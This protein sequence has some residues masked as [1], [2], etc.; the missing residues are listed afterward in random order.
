MSPRTLVA[1]PLIALAF[2]ASA[3]G[4][5]RGHGP[6]DAVST[7]SEG[8]IAA[9][10]SKGES[11]LEDLER[12]ARTGPETSRGWAV[13]AIAGM[14]GDEAEGVLQRIHEDPAEDMLVRSWAMAGRLQRAETVD[15]VLALSG[16]A[17]AFPATKRPLEQALSRV[18]GDIGSVEEALMLMTRMPQL[19]PALATQVAEAPPAEII[20]AMLTSTDNS[21]RWQAA[22][23]AA[24]AGQGK[25]DKVAR[26]TIEALQ[27]TPRADTPP[28]EGGALYIPGIAWDR[29]EAKVLVRSLA[30]WH[31]WAEETGNATAKGQIENNLRSVS[32]LRAAGMNSM[33]DA[34]GSN[35]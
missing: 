34:L 18:S 26:A 20:E 9:L 31:R 6:V 27:Y 35:R 23:Y 10:A 25:P 4:P 16:P 12:Q 21:V 2:A 33:A 3:H 30:L 19:Q 22:S 24:L 17:S 15:A 28:W 1:V 13:V 14:P 32:L 5:H 29:A 7:L 8:E 11:S